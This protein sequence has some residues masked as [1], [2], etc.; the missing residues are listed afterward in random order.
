MATYTKT[1]KEFNF[2]NF[3]DGLI[4]FF[5]GSQDLIT[6]QAEKY[7]SLKDKFANSMS[8]VFASDSEINIDTDNFVLDPDNEF[9]SQAE[10]LDGRSSSDDNMIIFKKDGDNV[11][12]VDSKE[13]P[14]SSLDWME[15]MVTVS[16]NF[17]KEGPDDEGYFAFGQVVPEDAEY[18]CKDCGYIEEISAGSIFPIC[19]VCL[20]GEPDGPSGPGEGYWEEV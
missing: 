11:R 7:S 6:A 1:D 8:I 17:G 19:E 10:K 5:T 12:V 9:V 14:D 16:E 4:V 15:A 20:A 3:N 2:N 13:D 18:L